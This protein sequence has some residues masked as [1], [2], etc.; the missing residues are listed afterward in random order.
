[1]P[2][3]TGHPGAA[4]VLA[5]AFLAGV[6]L[7]L[8][9]FQASTAYERLLL[10]IHA[11]QRS[12]TR[13]L[14]S[15]VRALRDSAGA[16]AFFTL[17]G[18]G[19]AYGV[20][21]AVGPGH[22]KAVITAYALTHESNAR[23]T[24]ALASGSA[25]IQGLTAIV[26][27]G[28]LSLLL[29]G[30]LRRAALSVDDVMEPVSYAA[31][32]AIGLYFTLRGSRALYRSVA[33]QFSGADGDVVAADGHDHDGHACHSHMISPTQVEQV[34]TWTRA[35]IIA[36]AVGLRPCTGAIVVL[37][38]TFALGLV[39][40][41]IAAVVAMSV[42]TAITVSIL[43][44]TAQGVRRPLLRLIDSGGVAAGTFA[45]ALALLGGLVI[46]MVGASLLYG[47]LV[48]P[49]HPFA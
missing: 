1:M 39:W 11:E 37:V 23:R 40:S 25:L 22:G 44:L 10:W 38:L 26:I 36:L 12:F 5:V 30:S 34:T 31:V 48:A 4:V 6:F 2:K 17:L 18:L 7:L 32:A 43:A 15:A 29:E 33:R 14:S 27:V 47:S 9:E 21:H 3:L 49:A 28:G 42:G 13:D 35:A 24:A 45:A 8:S 46:V 20:F 41:G 16:E 19:F